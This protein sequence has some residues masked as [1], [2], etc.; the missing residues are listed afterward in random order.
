MANEPHHSRRGLAFG[1]GIL[2]LAAVAVLIW[3][4]WRSPQLNHADEQVFNTVDALFTALTS[5]DL[6]RLN[7]C[8]RRLKDYKSK[9]RISDAAAASLDSIIQ[10]AHAGKWEPAARQLYDFMLGQRSRKV[11]SRST[12]K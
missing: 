9:G 2:G 8:E 6:S 1:G 4:P 7:E 11:S 10:K 3:S 5:R 12:E